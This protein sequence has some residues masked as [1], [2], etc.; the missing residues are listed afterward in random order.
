MPARY[1]EG[2]F[3]EIF[4]KHPQKPNYVLYARI[5]GVN[6]YV[7]PEHPA[8]IYEL[9]SNYGKFWQVFF[10]FDKLSW[11]AIAYLCRFAFS[12]YQFTIIGLMFLLLLQRKALRE[13][14][15]RYNILMVFIIIL[16]ITPPVIEQSIS[17]QVDGSVGSMLA[18]LL[19][20][21][22][23]GYRYKIYSNATAY[24][25]TFATSIF[26]GLGKNEWSIALIV[27]VLATMIFFYFISHSIEYEEYSSGFLLLIFMAGGL[28]MGNLI[29]YKFDPANYMGGVD[30]MLRINKVSSFNLFNAVLIKA[31]LIYVNLLLF[32]ILLFA[33]TFALK[34]TDF[35]LFLLF[36]WGSILFFGFVISSWAVDVRY[37]SPSFVVFLAGIVAAYDYFNSK[38]VFHMR[39]FLV[40]GFVLFFAAF[41]YVKEHIPQA[42]IYNRMRFVVASVD[43]DNKQ[44]L[45]NCIPFMDMSEALLGG[46]DFI[47]NSLSPQVAFEVAE[48]FNK[49]VC[50]P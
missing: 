23:I 45:K 44:N 9:I 42:G 11:A 37:Y 14:S 34:K 46:V 28:V 30:V 25:L 35:I 2:V 49:E 5:N 26:Y 32:G 10:N 40:A 47:S 38:N 24:L 15:T 16:A 22:I 12:L 29:S 36:T 6:Q 1:E 43:R 8:I 31:P 48:R 41:V 27:A 13:N 39:V 50:A 21:S 3:I 17:L 19:A 20:L 18:G 33:L 4:S 7:M